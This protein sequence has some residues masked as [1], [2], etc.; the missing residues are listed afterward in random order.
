MN[1]RTGASR[2]PAASQQDAFV[3]QEA[4]GATGENIVLAG[5]AQ[6]RGNKSRISLTW[7]PAENDGNINVMRDGV[8]IQTTADDGSTTD[9]LKNASGTTHAYQVCETDGGGCSNTVNVVI[10]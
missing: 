3:D 4:I 7:S 9:K 8:I 6:T 1:G 5:S 10:P 2:S